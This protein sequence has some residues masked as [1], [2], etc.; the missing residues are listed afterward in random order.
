MICWGN[1]NL[2]GT[3]WPIRIV[4]VVDNLTDACLRVAMRHRVVPDVAAAVGVGRRPIHFTND[5]V[6][7]PSNTSVAANGSVDI[8]G[9]GLFPVDHH[10]VACGPFVD[11]GAEVVTAFVEENG[12][13]PSI[14][15]IQNNWM[16]SRIKAGC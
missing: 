13:L 3:V 11:D 9:K 5:G 15:Q 2:I 12:R 16:V 6:G 14:T 7:I 1:P 8:E 10:V 4:G